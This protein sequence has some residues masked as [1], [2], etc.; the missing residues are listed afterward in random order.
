MKA[1]V[2][3][4]YF[5]KKKRRW[6]ILSKTVASLNIIGINSALFLRKCSLF[7]GC[8]MHVSSVKFSF[9]CQLLPFLFLPSIFF[10]LPIPLPPLLFFL[11]LSFLFISFLFFPSLFFSFFSFFSFSF[12]LFPS[13]TLF[14][15][16]IFVYF[17]FKHD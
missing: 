16:F 15:L 12:L 13:L 6:F 11:L 3:K 7:W 9:S 5:K 14:F 8:N 17:C 1:S 2:S 10:F 4:N